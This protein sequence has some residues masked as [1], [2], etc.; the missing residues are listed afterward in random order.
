M[1]VYFVTALPVSRVIQCKARAFLSIGAVSLKECA[2]ALGPVWQRGWLGAAIV[3]LAGAGPGWA[4]AVGAVSAV[5]L[6]REGGCGGMV[7]AARP[8][9]HN[10]VL[11]R[12]AELWAGGSS[13]MM[14]AEHSGYDARAT[15]SLHIRGP[16]ASTV[17][18]LRHEG[19]RTL[20]DANFREIGAYRRGVDTWIVLASADLV[21]DGS[22][23]PGLAR[24]VLELVNGVRARG[25]RCGS[26]SLS[27]APAL[28]MN[29]TLASVAHGHAFDM[30]QHDYFEHEDPAGRSP[31]DRVRAA[32]YRD[33]LVGENIA[34]GPNSADEVVQG[35]LD[36]P[37]HCEN[38]MDPRFTEMGIA[39]A[40]GRA[41]KRGLYWVQVLAAPRT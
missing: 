11:D 4:D 3:G 22:Q 41:T 28:A 33:R 12:A 9:Q 18:L 37:G 25:A 8:L 40:P 23:A 34:Y 36:S 1:R 13:P 32:G 39:Y 14:A 6:L 27:P 35:W 20:T 15:A 30:A 19:C 38:M 5:Q 29:E 16:E 7:P 24:R 26:R 10:P 2:L 31:A 21:P 17:Q